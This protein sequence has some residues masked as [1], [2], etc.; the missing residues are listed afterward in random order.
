MMFYKMIKWNWRATG[1]KEVD[2]PPFPIILTNIILSCLT[3]TGSTTSYSAI[4]ILGGSI[5]KAVRPRLTK[6]RIK[7]TL[8]SCPNRDGRR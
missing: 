8:S 5:G 1:R 4:L 7:Q 2:L 6:G 3:G